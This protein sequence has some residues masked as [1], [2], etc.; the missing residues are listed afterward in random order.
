[1]IYCDIDGVIRDLMWYLPSRPKKWEDGNIIYKIVKDNPN[2]L[3][4]ALQTKYYPVIL[5]HINH[6]M[7]LSHQPNDEWKLGTTHWL[8][9]YFESFGV[10]YV[11]TAEEK[12]RYAE[13][14]FLIEDYPFFKDYSKIILIDHK[15]NQNVN[16]FMRV[17]KPEEL[18]CI[19]SC[20]IKGGKL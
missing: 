13:N 10:I 9:R 4:Q 14:N 16:P 18:D 3:W 5:K 15:Y 8:R 1:M 17:K 11:D 6:I 7:F 2:I 12:M 19:I 20:I